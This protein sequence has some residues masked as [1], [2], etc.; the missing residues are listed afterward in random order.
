MGP[1]Y[2]KVQVNLK[3]HYSGATHIHG[4]CLFVCLFV[5]TRSLFGLEIVRKSKLAGLPRDQGDTAWLKPFFYFHSVCL[6]ECYLEPRLLRS[7]LWNPCLNRSRLPL[8]HKHPYQEN[9]HQPK[10]KKKD[11]GT[12]ASSPI[13]PKGAKPT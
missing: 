13:T 6:T 5:E 7:L 9:P 4:F 12:Q 11:F 3:C 1:V 8:Q 10:K 2:T